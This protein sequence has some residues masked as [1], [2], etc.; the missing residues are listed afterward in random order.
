ML[1]Y[2][3]KT[4][5]SKHCKNIMC[6]SFSKHKCYVDPAKSIMS[7]FTYKNLFEWF[8]ITD[9][10]GT[11]KQFAKDINGIYLDSRLQ[12]SEYPY[13]RELEKFQ[14]KGLRRI[15]VHMIAG[16]LNDGS[17]RTIEYSVIQQLK[18]IFPGMDIILLGPEKI[19]FPKSNRVDNI[20]GGTTDIRDVFDWIDSCDLFIGQD[21]VAA[22]YA[23]MTRKPTIIF[24]HIPSLIDH[25]WHPDWSEHVLAVVGQGNRVTHLPVGPTANRIFDLI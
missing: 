7:M 14:K 19:D 5:E 20:T 1:V 21:G 25:Y 6:T 24:Y 23:A 15:C 22:Y 11:A 10:A 18:R 4:K 13:L 16:R 2:T 9:P 12:T 8:K 17:K 3:M